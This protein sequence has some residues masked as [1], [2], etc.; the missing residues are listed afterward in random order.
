M[1]AAL[2]VVVLLIGLVGFGL[3]FVDEVQIRRYNKKH[4]LPSELTEDL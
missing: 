3:W 2:S 4:P 1:G